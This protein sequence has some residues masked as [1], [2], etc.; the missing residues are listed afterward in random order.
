M[1]ESEFRL[2]CLA[3]AMQT[4][5]VADVLETAVEYYRFVSGDSAKPATRPKL[6]KLAP[7]VIA[8]DDDD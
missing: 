1:T 3:L 2:E 6:L 7:R 8:D 5:N 4:P